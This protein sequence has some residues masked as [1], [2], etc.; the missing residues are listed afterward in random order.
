MDKTMKTKEL[1]N[2]HYEKGKNRNNENKKILSLEIL[3][4]CLDAAA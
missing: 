2:I 1:G 4:S 3:I